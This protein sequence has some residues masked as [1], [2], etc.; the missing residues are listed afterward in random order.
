MTFTRESVRKELQ[1][2]NASVPNLLKQSVVVTQKLTP[3]MEM[4]VDKALESE[5]FAE[6]KKIELRK[7]KEAG[8]FTKTNLAENPKIAKKIDEYV[9]REIKKS[10]KAGKLPTKKQLKELEPLW[11]EQEKNTS[12]S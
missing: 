3:I 12:T 6:E 9:T 4:V 8:Y 11:Q 10:I 7:L 2:I 5:D 1:R